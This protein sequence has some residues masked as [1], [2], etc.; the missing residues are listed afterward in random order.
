MS[1][2]AFC[3]LRFSLTTTRPAVPMW[4]LR[5]DGLTVLTAAERYAQGIACMLKLTTRKPYSRGCS[6]KSASVRSCSLQLSG[7]SMMQR[8]KRGRP[9]LSFHVLARRRCCERKSTFLQPFIIIS[10]LDSIVARTHLGKAPDL[11]ASAFARS[12]TPVASTHPLPASFSRRK[13]QKQLARL[14]TALTI[15]RL[16]TIPSLDRTSAL[17]GRSSPIAHHVYHL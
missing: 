7:R 8:F 12:L 15:R 6:H 14:S 4:I 9:E 10:Q 11:C 16:Y 2:G 1:T 13:S 5:R 3:F 17:E